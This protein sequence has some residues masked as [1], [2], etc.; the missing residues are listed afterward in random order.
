MRLAGR[1]AVDVVGNTEFIER[2]PDERVIAVHD[3][4]G[5]DALLAG[6]LGH[7][8]T[9]LIAATHEQYVLALQAQVSHVDVGRHI[10]TSQVTDVNR[11]VSIRQRRRH[12]RACKFLL[13][14]HCHIII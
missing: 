5:G 1:T 3:L 8:Y 14:L 12:Q 7:G 4:L 2:I 6:A 11:T 9:M 13:F 10:H